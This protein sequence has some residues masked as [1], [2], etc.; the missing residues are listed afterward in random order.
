MKKIYY[1]LFLSAIL[2]GSIS[3]VAKPFLNNIHPVLLSSM[4]YLVIGFTLLFIYIKPKQFFVTNKQTFGLI[5]L[6]GIFGGVCGPILYFTGLSLT[7]AS[8]ASVLINAEFIFTIVLAYFFLKERITRSAV[9]GIASIMT[10]LF[11]L[12]VNINKL[13]YGFED[14]YLIGNIL[15]ILSTLFWALDN[16]IT[17]V[18]LNRNTPIWTLLQLKSFIGGIISLSIIILLNISFTFKI[19]DLPSLLFLSLGGFASSLFLFMMGLKE[20]GAVKSVMIFSTS[21]LFGV[22]FAIILLTEQ[23]NTLKLVVSLIFVIVGIYLITR[24]TN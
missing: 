24:E 18:I 2:Y 8:I 5:I 14:Q 15:I 11:L 20:V 19:H 17:K 23:V 13:T 10:G 16:T 7:N 21:S 9:I 1:Y 22:V 12:N 6:V 4:V 3:T